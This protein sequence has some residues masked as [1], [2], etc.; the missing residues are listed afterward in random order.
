V[1]KAVNSRSIPRTAS[2][3]PRLLREIPDPPTHLE[4]AGKSLEPGPAIAIVGTRRASP[5]GLEVTEWLAAELA[6]TGVT[7]VSG[8][9]HGIDAAAHRG[10]LEVGGTTIAVLGSGLDVCYP[11][12]NR[13]LYR[14]IL[15]AGTLVSEHP[16][17]TPPLPYHFPIRNRII[18]GMSLAAVIVEARS[19]GGA[20]ITARLAAEYGRE[21]L[22]VPGMVHSRVSE[23]PHSL[24]R[25]GAR[26]VTSP[27][28]ILE[29]LGLAAPCPDGSQLPELRPDEQAVW[30]RLDVE[31][32]VLDL[33]ARKAKMPP[34]TVAAILVGLEM[35][36]H[37]SRLP[38]ARFARSVAASQ[39]GRS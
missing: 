28:D 39:A 26:L 16:A 7:V 15:E 5:Y 1:G 23:G 24:I 6:S 33:I 20:M 38:G 17:G 18:A 9:A 21:V 19:G 31:P 35:K 27:E 3:F 36:G 11:A 34:S 8:M 30:E 13:S 2:E 32:M 14:Q 22:A 25:D 12:A 37:A 29:D 4:V 10:A